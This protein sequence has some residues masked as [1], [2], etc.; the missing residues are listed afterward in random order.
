MLM[1]TDFLNFVLSKYTS[2]SSIIHI[3]DTSTRI[4]ASTDEKR[5][6]NNSNTAQYIVQVMR[7]AT[8]ESMV[9]DKTVSDTV[10]YG[11]PVFFDKELCGTVIV[12][13]P[14]N[15]AIQQGN[16]IKSSL[17]TA[18]EYERYRENTFDISD[19]KGMIAKYLLSDKID[20][21]KV[22]VLMTNQEMDPNLLR[23]VICV[24]LDYHQTSYFN[25]N[26]NLGYQSS[27]ER[28]KNEAIQRICSN[29]YFNSQ[30]IVHGL[31]RNTIIIIK[32]FIPVIDYSRIYLSLDKICGEI[33]K[34]L[35]SFT[36]FS[37]SMAYGNLYYGITELNKSFNEAVE[38]I[39]IGQKTK[40]DENF[41]I[42]ENILFDNICHFLHP[43]ITNK[44]LLPTIHKLLRK[45]GTI[46]SDLIECAEVYVDNCMNFSITSEKTHLHRNTISAKLDKMEALTGLSPS[47]SFRDAF[48]I[49]MLAVYLRHNK[50]NENQ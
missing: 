17:E 12:R 11:T 5:V 18:L 3:T 33:E 35:I 38:I 13:G 41:Y 36:T 40:A 44:L 47:K 20:L 48:I 16:T 1:N 19:D 24:K 49:K 14:S 37:F 21:E 27:T 15:I 30:D 50:P 25:I 26:L 39:G 34:T 45:D 23:T 6:G 29:K 10:L 42:L 4:L 2:T 7:P 8:I 28:I 46:M 9:D 22:S 31:D 43:Q 32:S